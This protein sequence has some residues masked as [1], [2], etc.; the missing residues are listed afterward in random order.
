MAMFKKSKIGKT[1]NLMGLF[2]VYTYWE[3]YGLD[4]VNQLTFDNLRLMNM[5][6]TPW[7][8]AAFLVHWIHRKFTR[9]YR[10]SS[11]GHLHFRLIDT[12]TK[13]TDMTPTTKSG[14]RDLRYKQDIK[15]TTVYTYECKACGNTKREW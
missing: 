8:S 2:M 3:A 1:L 12:H 6:V 11:C 9:A 7:F 15:Y 5:Y 13:S 10:C 4:I 14:A